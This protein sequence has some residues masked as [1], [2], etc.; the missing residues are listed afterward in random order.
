[1]ENAASCFKRSSN[2]K[3]ECCRYNFLG[4]VQ[5]ATE[6]DENGTVPGKRTVGSEY[7]NFFNAILL[8]VIRSNHDVR[9]I[10]CCAHEMYYTIK[11]VVKDQDSNYNIAA[12]TIASYAKRLKNE[13]T[14][15]RF[16]WPKQCTDALGQWHILD[17]RCSSL[18]QF[19][20]CIIPSTEM[21]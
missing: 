17:L 15:N 19:Q 2:S 7:I 12:I 3:D 11:Y 8:K 14:S 9:F 6:M 21:L 4:L 10:L 16:P 20:P 1:M 5:R 13:N 18:V